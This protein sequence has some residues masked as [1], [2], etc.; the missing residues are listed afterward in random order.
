MDRI[1]IVCD[2]ARPS[3]ERVID[4][5]VGLTSA[6]MHS[7]VISGRE[8][9]SWRETHGLKSTSRQKYVETFDDSA[10]QLLHR[11]ARGLH[12]GGR[13][14]TRTCRVARTI[15]DISHHEKVTKDDVSEAVAY[16][17]RSLE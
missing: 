11:F 6:G 8:F 3:S 4:G 13:A 7:L 16:R 15:A 12:L 14:I 17:S 9:A 5:E 10:L 2:V 1:D